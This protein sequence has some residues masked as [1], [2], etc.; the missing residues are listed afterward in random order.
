[1]NEHKAYVDVRLGVGF[2]KWVAV[3]DISVVEVLPIRTLSQSPVTPTVYAASGHV[4]IRTNTGYVLH[5]H[6]DAHYDSEGIPDMTAKEV[7]AMAGKIAVRYAET[8]LETLNGIS[9]ELIRVPESKGPLPWPHGPEEE[10]PKR[11]DQLACKHRDL[12]ISTGQAMRR[13]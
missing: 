12:L 11:L 1:M 8:L 9:Q 6:K 3:E 7:V 2:P 10:N 4:E 5:T 13:L